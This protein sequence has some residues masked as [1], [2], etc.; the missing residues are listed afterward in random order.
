MLTHMA[1]YSVHC[2]HYNWQGC[3]MQTQ[4]LKKTRKTL[5]FILKNPP[6]IS[7][8]KSPIITQKYIK[9]SQNAANSHQYMHTVYILWKITLKIGRNKFWDAEIL[10]FLQYFTENA[11]L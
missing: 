8:W 5:D 3:Q 9:F 2:P 4:T 1:V 6:K 7:A 11:L 10:I